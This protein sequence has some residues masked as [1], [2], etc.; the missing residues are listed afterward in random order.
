MTITLTWA[1]GAFDPYTRDQASMFKK[2]AFAFLGVG[3]AAQTATAQAEILRK[4]DFSA[5]IQT[6]TDTADLE[7]LDLTQEGV[8]FPART[9]REI[10]VKSHCLTDNDHFYYEWTESV[11]GG[12]TPVL[13]GQKIIDGWCDEAGTA[14]EYGRLHFKATL[15][16]VSTP[17]V[18]FASK[19]LS[20]DAIT[21]GA[22][23]FN[24]PPNRL[25]LVKGINY[26]GS[27]T[28]ST[29]SGNLV[30]VDTQFLGGTNGTDAIQFWDVQTST[31][32]LLDNPI[33]GADHI[34]EIAFEVWP[35]HN[36]RLVL[37]TNNVTIKCTSVA[38][39]GDEN[40]KHFLEV[41]VGPA[42]VIGYSAV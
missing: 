4:P 11:L 26:A 42:R 14:S 17:V 8:T 5:E 32:L 29:P 35:P 37:D 31:Q 20:I 6:T 25:C 15:S 16:S 12:T 9:I 1:T 22:A 2:L 13:M 38:Q 10:R 18:N 30:A 41:F 27:L 19:G 40:L 7:A 36:H 33:A 3:T 28:T 39:I 24:V 34:L 23:D 21:S